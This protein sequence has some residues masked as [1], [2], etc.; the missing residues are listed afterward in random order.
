M[1]E[2]ATLE[3]SVAL[4]YCSPAQ[5]EPRYMGS[6]RMR[7][8][9]GGDY[10]DQVPLQVFSFFAAPSEMGAQTGAGPDIAV[11]D[12]KIVGMRGRQFDRVN[13]GRLGPKG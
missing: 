12:G 8:V 3:R 5:R 11:K 2:S 6:K 13:K 9:S 10:W 4:T 7:D 1:H